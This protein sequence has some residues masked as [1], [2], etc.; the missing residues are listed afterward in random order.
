MENRSIDSSF[1]PFNSNQGQTML[2]RVPPAARGAVDPSGAAPAGTNT[3]STPNSNPDP[4]EGSGSP[5]ERRQVRCQLIYLILLTYLSAAPAPI[6]LRRGVA[7]P[8]SPPAL[9]AERSKKGL[10][11]CPGYREGEERANTGLYPRAQ[12]G[13]CRQAG[14]GMGTAQLLQRREAEAAAAAALPGTVARGS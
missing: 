4:S 7:M 14:R 8:N 13:M 5:Q 10:Q 11:M 6:P 12:A 3:P 2:L 9:A 1:S